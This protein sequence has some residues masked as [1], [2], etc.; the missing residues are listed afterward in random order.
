[1]FS[2]VDQALLDQAIDGDL[3]IIVQAGVVNPGRNQVYLNTAMR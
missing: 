1:M 2:D 3:G